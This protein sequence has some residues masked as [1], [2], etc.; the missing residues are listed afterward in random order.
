DLCK[1]NNSNI[2]NFPNLRRADILAL[3]SKAKVF[4]P[5]IKRTFWNCHYRIYGSRLSTSSTFSQWSVRGNSKEWKN[6]A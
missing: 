3:L 5:T 1:E 2:K 4:S 6:M